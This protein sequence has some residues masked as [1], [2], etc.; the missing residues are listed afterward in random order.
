MNR[1]VIITRFFGLGAAFVGVMAL[2]GAFIGAVVGMI[3]VL[4]SHTVLGLSMGAFELLPASV[5]IG[6][7]GF[8]CL[9]VAL[10]AP[11][12]PRPVFRQAAITANSEVI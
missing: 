4:L 12:A 8:L 10:M 7:T 2:A 1:F 9:G 6:A 3:L 5:I 11:H